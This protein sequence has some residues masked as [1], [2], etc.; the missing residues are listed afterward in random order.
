MLADAG[1]TAL[2][3]GVPFSDP[4]ADGPTIQLSSQR[5]LEAG[6]TLEQILERVAT[7]PSYKRL[8]IVLMSYV[9]P[10]VIHGIDRFCQGA[11]GVA[12]VLLSDLPPEEMPEL[13]ASVRSAGLETVLLV[14]PTTK[15][16][17][18]PV[19]AAAASGYVYC[20]TRTGVTG[21]GGAFAGNLSAQI[22]AVRA[23]TNVPV[24]A[25]FGVRSPEDAARLGAELDGVIVGARI[26]EILGDGGAD[27]LREL[28]EFA[29]GVVGALRSSG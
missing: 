13:W 8:P 28:R 4:L 20:V 9:N 14:A 27:R 17:R 23:N 24:L 25:G 19:L 1:A 29:E 11:S 22:A 16:E 18:V 7:R 6:V 3:L 2:E 5:A 26:I 21:K 10:I 15:A 12:G